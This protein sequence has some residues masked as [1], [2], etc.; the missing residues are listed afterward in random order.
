MRG[1]WLDGVAEELVCG[2]RRG[3]SL[4]WA[5]AA[6]PPWIPYRKAER[7]VRW[8]KKVMVDAVPPTDNPAPS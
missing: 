8:L 3:R 7:W 1:E 5:I 6:T 4:R 2:M